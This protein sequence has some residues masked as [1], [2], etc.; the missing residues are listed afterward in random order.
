MNNRYFFALF[1][2]FSTLEPQGSRP[3]PIDKRVGYSG[4]SPA[5]SMLGKQ[6]INKLITKTN[7]THT[8]INLFLSAY[9]KQPVTQVT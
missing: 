4:L 5:H 1:A 2:A 8:L 6:P 7:H 3:N 9:H